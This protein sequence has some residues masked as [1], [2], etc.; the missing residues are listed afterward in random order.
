MRS[1]LAVAGATSLLALG[2]VAGC[3]GGGGQD[4]SGPAAT[5]AAAASAP[6][7]SRPT[8]PGEVVR[9]GPGTPKGVAQALTKGQ[10]V[11]VAFLMP[12]TA[13][14]DAVRAALRTARSSVAGR[15]V[16][17]FT[18][19][20]RDAKRFGDLPELLDVTVTPS[21]AVIGRDRRLSNLFRGLTDANLIRQAM[22]EAKS[23]A[24]AAG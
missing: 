23:V 18:Y 7:V 17:V 1:R 13:D 6:Q 4:A 11:V 15:G 20:L 5:P 14:D 16:R 3:G 21:V 10:A 2:L 24:R 8:S 22:S 9:P 19:D 12:G